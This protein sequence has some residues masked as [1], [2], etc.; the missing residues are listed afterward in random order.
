[1]RRASIGFLL[2]ALLFSGY[3]GYP[4]AARAFTSA[5]SQRL[6][7]R[8]RR[9]GFVERAV[10]GD[11]NCQFRAV[12]DQL[13]GSEEHHAQLRASAVKW[14]KENAVTPLGDP[15]TASRWPDFLDT[16]EFHDWKAYV[17]YIT[18]DGSWGDHLSLLALAEALSSTMEVISSVQVKD[19]NDPQYITRVEPQLSP[20]QRTMYLSHLHERHY[21]SLWKAANRR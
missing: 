7:D 15:A 14:L 1:M 17:E 21:N 10:T 19:E 12:S 4:L 6:Q 2:S 8:L 16:D 5:H 18:K 20:S 11:G 13:F 3:P 9:H